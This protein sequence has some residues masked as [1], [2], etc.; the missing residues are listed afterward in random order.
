MC[1]VFIWERTAT[2]ATYSINWSVFITEMKSVYCAVRTVSLNKAVCASHLKSYSGHWA[3]VRG[4]RRCGQSAATHWMRCWIGPRTDMIVMGKRKYLLLRGSNSRC[5]TDLWLQEMK[6][7][8][9]LDLVKI[10]MS[11]V[12]KHRTVYKTKNDGVPFVVVTRYVFSIVKPV[13]VD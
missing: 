2:C 13:A 1:F 11:E 10:E 7:V 5:L 6:Q 8:T 3:V 12:F 4:R 9:L